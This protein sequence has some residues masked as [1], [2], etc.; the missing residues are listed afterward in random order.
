MRQSAVLALVISLI[1]VGSARANEQQ[2]LVAAIR[3]LGKA[4]DDMS[5][6]ISKAETDADAEL[7]TKVTR[8]ALASGLK[9]ENASVQIESSR[10]YCRVTIETVKWQLW[11][12]ARR[13][14]VIDHGATIH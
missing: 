8:E 12:E 7:L 6:N 3:T 11:S 4:V 10:G 1:M 14:K 13:G 9:N 2:Q 5:A